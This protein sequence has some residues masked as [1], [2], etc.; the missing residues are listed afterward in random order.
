[1]KKRILILL[2]AASSVWFGC[3]KKN[4]ATPL[5][6]ATAT[7]NDLVGKW[8]VTQTIIT[9]T[10]NNETQTLTET[11]NP[12][13][14]YIQFNSDKTGDNGGTSGG[15]DTFT[16]SIADGIIYLTSPTETADYTIVAITATTL[17]L[18]VKA[19][20]QNEDAYLSK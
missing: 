2:V 11:F 3:S 8:N 18:R 20:N 15:A 9:D 1:M 14:L 16:Y 17:T 7:V 12:G 19:P 10:V 13:D 4:E 6:P 5:T